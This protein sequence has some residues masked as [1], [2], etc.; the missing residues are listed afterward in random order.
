MTVT[1]DRRLE[2]LQTKRKHRG[3]CEDM[4][5]TCRLAGQGDGDR[6]DGRHSTPAERLGH[7]AR[8]T[9]S[10]DYPSDTLHIFRYSKSQQILYYYLE[11]YL[12]MTSL[13]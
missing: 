6:V 3:D 13:S 2:N 9:T 11:N 10:L 4:K 5:Q 7:P 12:I 8:H 1:S